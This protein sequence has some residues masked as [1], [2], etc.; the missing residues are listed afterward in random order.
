[1]VNIAIDALPALPGKS[2]AVGQYRIWMQL[3]PT[4]HKNVKVILFVY[5]LQAE[6]YNK[7]LNDNIKNKVSFFVIHLPESILIRIAVQNILIPIICWFKNIKVHLS[8]NPEPLIKL[9]GILE[10]FKIADLQ[11][12]ESPKEFGFFKY[13]YRKVLGA[14]KVTK[15]GFIIANSLETKK[16]ILQFYKVDPSKI[17][18]IY[19]SYDH[20]IFN[21]DHD[22]LKDNKVLEKYNIRT[23]YILYVSSFRPYKNH[24]DLIK[25]FSYVKPDY[26]LKLVLIGNDVEGYKKK[27]NEIIQESKIADRVIILDYIHHWE[28]ASIYRLAEIFIYPSK[29]ETFGI[30]LLEAMACGCPVIASNY[31]CIPEIAGDG[32]VI[33]DTTNHLK[34]A[35]MIEDVLSNKTIKDDLV[36]RGKEWCQRY[37]WEENI[38]T[39]MSEI[40]NYINKTGV[41]N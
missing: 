26:D 22:R 14:R 31:S 24:F 30:P 20:N 29:L 8:L 7:F 32:A 41:K 9:F 28:L 13:H 38:K 5:P 2:G 16:K 17:K 11:F 15:S 34:F 12:L 25:T 21:I 4:L 1:L 35:K 6:Y 19:E 3:L 23:P 39:M 37:T 10:V 18:V 33:I 36:K 27:I 40:E